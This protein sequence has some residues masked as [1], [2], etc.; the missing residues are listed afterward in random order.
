M[1][2]SAEISSSLFT[3]LFLTLCPHE[4]REFS[5]NHS[6]WIGQDHSLSEQQT[7]SS[8]PLEKILKLETNGTVLNHKTYAM[9][10]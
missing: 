9:Q 2:N 3:I 10:F 8:S 4:K 5:K 6:S 7:P 1:N